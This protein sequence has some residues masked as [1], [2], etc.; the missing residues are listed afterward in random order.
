[1]TQTVTSMT[2][3]IRPNF[4][5]VQIQSTIETLLKASAELVERAAQGRDWAG[6]IG[7]MDAMEATLTHQTS[8]NSHLNA[9]MFDADFSAEYEKTLPLIADFYS[10][11]GSNQALYQ[12]YQ[13]L[14]QTSLNAQQKHILKDAILA[15]EL[16]GV[17]LTGAKLQRFKAIQMRLSVAQHQFS[18]NTLQSTNAWKKILTRDELVGYG[19]LELAKVKTDK[20]FEISLQ[21]PI[22][23]DVMTYARDRS[24][25]E[26]VYK[27]YISRASS[28]GIT[29][30]RFDNTALMDEVLALRFEM[31][32]LL[33]FENY[34]TLSIA[35]KMVRSPKQVTD[36]LND[37]V[38]R[39]KPQA[40]VELQ[41]LRDF[42]QVDLMPW[43]VAYYSEQL[44]VQ[45]YG[46]KK[47]EL[48]AYFPEATVLK[49]LF[50]TLKR[51][52]QIDITTLDEECYHQDVR[53][54]E[55]RRSRG[56]AEAG[57]LVGRIY[58]DMYAREN[59]RGG[60][61]MA[62][63]QSLSAE[64]RPIAFVVCSLNSPTSDVPALFEFDEVI[65]LFHEFGHAMHH[66]LTKVEY[67]CAAGIS[68]VP[69][70]G[71][72]LPS[73]YMELFCYEREVIKALS[74]HWQTGESLPEALYE[75]L[76]R[77]KNFQSAM[78]L[79]RQC[80]FS[81]WDIQTH[82]SNEDTYQVLDKVRA[83]TALLPLVGENRF[84]NTFGHIFSGGYAAGYFS[85]KWAEV[86]AA[87]AYLYT[88]TNAG[89]RDLFLHCILEVG[90]SLDFMQQYI[91]F[92]GEMPSVEALLS[93]SG[94]QD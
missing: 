66:L 70:D 10:N 47:S 48:S 21:P 35:T 82:L 69:W 72:E 15:F 30:V 61:W 59:K 65:T 54:L 79:L 89:A 67:P 84:L 53:V 9:V 74:A 88:Q 24:L 14:R 29:D 80:E 26:C 4:H 13:R 25:R 50:A 64:D 12:A 37:L 85:Y 16:S 36:F 76:I 6:V 17:G 93:S 83:Q 39:A 63:Y 40:L 28:V 86:L 62:D 92:R 52:Y 33:G 71:V 32:E 94:I 73:Q 49:G 22:Y 78:Q 44:K 7:V 91:A 68:G 58:L 31:A 38:V 18:T 57:A 56:A 87:D 60:A 46:F 45:T 41:A 27:A 20:G 75:Q 81:L 90:G 19:A 77:A 8:V 1:M 11:V 34:A 51:L 23:M 42:A 55:V 43:D 2:Q 3:N 5:T